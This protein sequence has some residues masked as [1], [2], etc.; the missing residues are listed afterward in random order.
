M[1]KRSVDLNLEIV[2][3][4][5]QGFEGKAEQARLLINASASA[6]ADAAKFQLVYADELATPDYQYYELFQSLEMDDATWEKLA[7]YA[8]ELRIKLYVDIFGEKSLQLAEK[9]GVET[10]KL[11]GTDIA[12]IGLLNKVAHSSI[13]K[14]ML[15]AGGAYRTE[16]MKAIDILSAKGK[17]IVVLLGFQG[18]PTPTD[19]NQIARVKLLS[20]EIVE[21]FTNVTVGFADHA[22][23][24]SP[25]AYA[26]SATAIGAGAR[27]IEK[28]LTLAKSM[29][30][31]DHEAALNPDEFTTFCETMRSCLRA[32]GESNVQEDFGMSESELGYR[33]MIRRHVVASKN[34]AVGTELSSSDLV[35]KRTSEENSIHSLELAYGKR[36]QRQLN[37]NAPVLENDLMGY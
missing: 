37:E 14:V 6:G 36:I 18:Y 5:A 20:E 12:N 32:F 4:L 29:K 17:E 15:G 23:P 13:P 7:S 35:L 21:R 10:I 2:A 11:H 31:E 9:I 27:V 1:I 33:T 19:M 26:L 3:E 16:L 24:E 34:L 22:D 25:L 30:L 28:H 8:R